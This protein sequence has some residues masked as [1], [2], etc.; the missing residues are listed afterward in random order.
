M[1]EIAGAILVAVVVG[2]V[3]FTLGRRAARSEPAAP[4]PSRSL[5]GK[6]TRLEDEQ[7]R[8]AEIIEGMSEGVVVFGDT[9]T[10]VLAN[11]AARR[12]LTL[13][14]GQLPPRIPSDEVTSTARRSL[15]ERKIIESEL[16]WNAAGLSLRVRAIPL[17]DDHGVVMFLSDVTDELRTQQLRRQFVANAS[18]ELKTPVASLKTLVEAIQGSTA[19]DPDAT[20]RFTGQL[21]N[22]TDRLAALI[23]DLMDLSRVEDPAAMKLGEVDLSE[24][25]T[26][27]VKEVEDPARDAGIALDPS[28]AERVRVRG[29]ERHLELMVRNLLSNAVRYTLAGGRVSVTL[30]TDGGRAA[31]TVRD[32][33]IG[34]PLQAQARVFERFY[35]VDQDRARASGGTGLG[36][37]IVKNVAESHGGTVALTSE[38]D[39]GST[40][41]VVLPLAEKPA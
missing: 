33:G 27:E 26:R 31:L 5:F 40:F 15:S 28:I 22:E 12:L 19:T 9:L 35:R 8:A 10:P 34:I 20:E 13:P 6:I 7:R 30:G 32:T 21:S 39:E 24:V 29:D 1:Q 2:I 18:H 4:D 41:T 25:V 38:L 11:A 14:G 23:D 3:M 16:N 36:L 17:A 37:S